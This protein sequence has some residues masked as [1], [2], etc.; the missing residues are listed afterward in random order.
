MKI[1]SNRQK[2]SMLGTPAD[3]KGQIGGEGVGHVT[4]P[5]N[6]RK[7]AGIKGSSKE[8]LGKK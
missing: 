2:T 1:S 4:K 8:S 7:A 5:W 6:V 3:P